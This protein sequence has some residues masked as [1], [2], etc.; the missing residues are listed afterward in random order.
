[1]PRLPDRGT[2]PRQEPSPSSKARERRTVALVSSTRPSRISRRSSSGRSY[3]SSPSSSSTSKSSRLMAPSAFCTRLKRG[4]PC[5]S[6]A[7]TSPSTT[8]FGLRRP[9]PRSLRMRGKRSARCLP[10]ARPQVRLAVG[11]TGEGAVASPTSPRGATRRRAAASRRRDASM[12]CTRGAGSGSSGPDLLSSSQLRGSPGF[13]RRRRPSVHSPCRRSP[14]S[15][16][17]SP[18]SRLASTSSYVPRS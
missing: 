5:S 12:G 1:M 15:R 17:V 16:S 6:N 13:E 18:P 4:T 14:S 11:Q 8:Q 2:G 10:P 9:R 7:T 3:S